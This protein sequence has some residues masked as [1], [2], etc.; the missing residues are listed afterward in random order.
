M[1]ALAAAGLLGCGSSGGSGGSGGIHVDAHAGGGT[2]GSG[3]GTGGSGGGGT[4]GNDGSAAT[5]DPSSL[6][7]DT[8]STMASSPKCA[9]TFPDPDPTAPPVVQCTTGGTSTAMCTRPGTTPVPGIDTCAPGYYCSAL[10]VA[11]P[12][13]NRQCR[14]VCSATQATCASGENCMELSYP[15]GTCRGTCDIFAA[16]GNCP[17]NNPLVP[18][19]QC[20]WQLTVNITDVGGM[21][22]GEARS[23]CLGV[24]T[25]IT[26]ASQ[27][28][29][30]GQPCNP[31]GVGGGGATYC[32]QGAI[33]IGQTGMSHC[34]QVC[35][36][37]GQH[38]CTATAGE[39]CI[40]GVFADPRDATGNTL[41]SAP[42]PNMGGWCVP[43][44]TSDGG[45]TLW[46]RNW[47]VYWQHP[48]FRSSR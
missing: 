31:N 33:C 2:G 27:L 47:A 12:G 29:P 17:Q 25:M 38:N 4:G 37:S 43:P 3:G 13:M 21:P 30:A 42:G 19:S 5:C 7:G 9:I 45:Q 10:A 39:M 35:D 1:A 14:R 24:P 18:L 22:T 8:C 20:S 46:D 48:K 34:A 28:K 16:M 11:G 44:Q 41:L 26:M 15:Y 36:M 6:T 23:T 40:P 32:Q